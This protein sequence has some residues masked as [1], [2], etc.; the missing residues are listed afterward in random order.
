MPTVESRRV[1]PYFAR[2][3]YNSLLTIIRQNAGGH[4]VGHDAIVNA[5]RTLAAA[6]AR[7]GRRINWAREQAIAQF[8]PRGTTK[9]N[10]LE[11]PLRWCA[12]CKSYMQ[13]TFKGWRHG[14][15]HREPGCTASAIVRP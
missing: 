7:R 14:Q 6:S 11:E 8:S 5:R 4:P 12:H 9:H 15:G 3:L 1:T 10:Y 13:W 2:P